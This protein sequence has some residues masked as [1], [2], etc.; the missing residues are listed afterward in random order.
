MALGEIIGLALLA[1]NL[2]WTIAW[3]M[4]MKSEIASAKDDDRITNHRERLVK[5]E[6]HLAHFPDKV[7]SHQ[8]VEKVHERVSSLRGVVDQLA[9]QIGKI[10]TQVSAT[11]ATVES[12]NGN[13]DLLN[14]SE[15]LKQGRKDD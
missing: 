11:A 4:Y 2:V 3:S 1:L 6:A 10:G 7:A 5:L 13:L 12:M 15:L 8:D 14:R 9:R